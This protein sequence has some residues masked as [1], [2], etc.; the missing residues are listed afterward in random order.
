MTRGQSEE[1]NHDHHEG[2]GHTHG[3]VDPSIATSERGIWAV[4]WSFVALFV[5]ALLQLGV[6]ILSGSVALL[7]D[8]IH[9]FGDAATA[10]PLY[11]QAL[12]LWLWAGRRPGGGSRCAH[13]PVLGSRCRLPGYR[14]AHQPPT[15]RFPGNTR[16][17]G[18]RRVLGQRSGS[19]LSH[20]GG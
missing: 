19:D 8:T 3:A 2:H 10:T 7:S 20:S 5:T 15:H 1:H 6:V 16:G 18:D 9:N 14:K 13:H 17:S 12:P 4:K 11:E